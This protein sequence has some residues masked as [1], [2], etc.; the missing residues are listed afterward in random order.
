MSGL[1]MGLGLMPRLRSCARF[2][3][4][5]TFLPLG[6]T[7][8][9]YGGTDKGLHRYTEAYERHL[10]L[11]RYRRNLVLE[12]GV[13]GFE[14]GSYANPKP[15]GSLRIWRDHLPFSRIVGFDIEAK[16]V[17]LGSRVSFIQGD[18]ASAVD[19]TKVIETEGVPDIVIDDGSHLVD[20]GRASFEYLF[21]LMRP[22]GLYVIEDLHTSYWEG[23]GGDIPAPAGTAVGF[24]KDMVDMVQAQDMTFRRRSYKPGAPTCDH[25][26][27]SVHIY[28]GI[29]FVEKL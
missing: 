21:P 16:D 20:H 2:A 1:K 6:F 18:Q 4:L 28:P 26:L 5:G 24:V 12:I 3:R 11:R 23:W 14:D 19:L 22:G 15:G 27:A 8:R 7:I 25:A 10:K 29:V 17:K 9:A 13:G